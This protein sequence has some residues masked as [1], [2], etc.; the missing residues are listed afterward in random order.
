MEIFIRPPIIYPIAVTVIFLLIFLGIFTKWNSGKL[1]KY[2]GLI[3][4]VPFFL[5]LFSISIQKNTIDINDSGIKM[6]GNI[7]ITIS[8][9]DIKSVNYEK[10]YRDSGYKLEHKK[11]GADPPGHHVGYFELENKKLSYCIVSASAA[12]AVIIETQKDLYLLSFKNITEVYKEI[13]KHSITLK[14]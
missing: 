1:Q 13:S 9:D 4:A 10:N 6:S 14:R 12:D 11:W 3:V 2:F 8:W 5:L 7:N